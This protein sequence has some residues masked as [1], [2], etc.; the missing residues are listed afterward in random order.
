LLY[1]LRKKMMM[2]LIK[3]ILVSIGK[4]FK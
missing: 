2:R 1:C 3:G 4:S